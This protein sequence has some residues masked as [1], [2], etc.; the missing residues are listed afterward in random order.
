[1]MAR[2]K[3]MMVPPVGLQESR[4]I[5]GLPHGGTLKL[6][7]VFFSFPHYGVPPIR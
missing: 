3:Q 4:F 7:S 6:L 2:L 5:K 1:M